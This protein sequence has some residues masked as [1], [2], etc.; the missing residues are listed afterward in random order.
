METIRIRGARTHNLKNINLDLPRDQLIVITGLSG[1]G[2]S[3]LAFDTLYAEGQRRYVESL[4]AYARQFLQLMEKPD[5]DLIEG[6]SPA[7]SIE[8]KATSHN[9]RST[10]G[11]V[12]E[13][14]DYL[15]LLYARAGTPYCP[16]HN[17][18]LEAQTVSQ[19]VDHVLA[20]PAETKLMILAP[21]VA[22]RKG[23]QM[24]LFAE[25]RAQ[26]FARVRVDGTVYEIDAVPKLAKSQKHNVDV[27][28]DRLKVRDD[29]RQ[30]LAESFETAL[31]HAEGRAVALE[32][33]SSTE[34]LFSAKFACPVCSYALQELEPRLFSF[35]NPMGACPKCDGLGVIQFF[36]PK[37]VVTNTAA[38]L[39]S[40][41][42]RG[43]DK[44]NQFYFQIIES[45]AVHYDFS[46]E[47]PWQELAE[48][49]RQLILY[50]SGR[51]EINFRYLNDKGTRFDRS[52][53]FEG[54]IPNL[55]RRYRGSDSAAV[56]EELAKYI[57]NSTC[58]TCN[59]TRLRT[60]ARHVGVGSHTLHEISRLPLGEVRNYFNCLQ[61][62]GAKAQVADK[63]LKEITA[64]LSFLINV[65]LD[66]LCLERSAET[67]SGGEAQR[68][69]LASQI[70][71]GL[72][73]V[74]YVLD[75]PSIGLHQRDNDRLLETLKNLRDM[76][77][78]VLVV[79]H[80]EDAIR[81][82][83]Y[84]IDIGPGAGVHGGAIVAQG[85]PAE[86]SANPLSMTGDY[87]A[88]RRAI[89]AP[90]Q[91]RP[92]NPER[93]LKVVGAY[94]NNLKDVT[95]EIPGGLL[96]C[97]TGVSGSGKSTLINDT[98]YAAAAKHLYGSTTEP[99][100]HKEIVGLDLFDKVINVDQAPI[101]RTPRSNPATYTGLLT[102]I[103]EL[104]AQV[105][106]SRARGYGP[107]RFSFNVKGGRCEACQGDGMIKVEMHFLP[108]IY[109]PCDVCHGKRYNR[110]TLEIN[111]KGK[112][113]HDILG[114]TVEQAREFF[115]AVP[116]VARKLQTLVDVGL[117]YITLG[118]SATT[119]S[120]GEAQRVKLALELSKRDTGRTLYILDEPTTG[121]HF[122]DIEML[123]SV[124]QRLAANGN[125]I[126]VI[127]HNLDVIK[128]ADW[129]VD[130]GPEGGEGGG[131]ILTAG[132]PE[133]VAK[134]KTSHTGR[135]LKPLLEKPKP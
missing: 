65:G 110:E 83:D 48:E 53:T 121:L 76:G 47:T 12:T 13:I 39:A 60:E 87:L 14:H 7:I 111:Y 98:L 103:R 11:T 84:V 123:L 24:D 18:P 63:I 21:V 79:E 62:T 10:V 118:Q 55:E 82:A 72:T 38:S 114:M 51:T 77:N 133:Q 131:R 4:S 66:Y 71:S 92:W 26:G 25:L 57:S 75:E 44:K 59:G 30:R 134:C 127:E 27:V 17:L 16:D 15:R 42:I 32:M 3:S 86:V 69:R 109:V 68:I 70:G 126:V 5:V 99:A 80:D 78:T 119:L 37:R 94:G 129:I 40:G 116:V 36:D 28:I 96:T 112:N 90:K 46:V 130:L 74:M 43:W 73:G 34:H 67:L 29:M 33:D 56:R 132:T 58:P 49:H 88:G 91:R 41:A 45:I 106:E 85:T 95:L 20:L 61:L 52:H 8:Q 128:T 108:D 117:S 19:M 115:D 100:P 64:R 104:F 81:N 125:T 9:P 22:N 50:G 93:V 97:I 122:Q 105:P 2:K 89:L 102:P 124:L 113:I 101:G 31:R 135:F 120:G 6:L 107:G 23:E 35:N 1:S 54:I